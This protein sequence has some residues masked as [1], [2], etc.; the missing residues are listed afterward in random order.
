MVNLQI[1]KKY[2]DR[3][4]NIVEIVSCEEFEIWEETTYKGICTSENNCVNY[5]TFGG[6][7]FPNQE[8]K[9]DLIEEVIEP[10]KE[11]EFVVQDNHGN[12]L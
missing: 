9:Y 11:I 10:E 2:K 8:S 6:R 4:G 5:F 3:E 12:K 1:G 7:F